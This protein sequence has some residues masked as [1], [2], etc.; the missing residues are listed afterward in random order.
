MQAE[1]FTGSDPFA[2]AWGDDLIV[3]DADPVMG[4]L[5]RAYDKYGTSILGVQRLDTDDIVKYGV[6]KIS[7]DDGRGHKCEAIIEK[8]SLDNIPSR[9][10]SL[11]RYVCD[12]NVYA[13]IRTTRP[14]KVTR[15][16]LPTRSTRF[17]ERAACGRTS[18]RVS[19]TIWATNSARQKPPSSSRFAVRS[20][21]I[22]SARTL[23]I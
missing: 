5:I 22:R 9:L 19:D 4:Q 14:E 15:F 3:N 20:S 7:E 23:K 11:G 12:K 2:L 16:S 21:G 13:A 17:A 10:T 1:K 6:A 8:P 18:S